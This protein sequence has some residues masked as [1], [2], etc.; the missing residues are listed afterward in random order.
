MLQVDKPT[1][2]DKFSKVEKSEKVDFDKAEIVERAGEKEGSLSE[3][4]A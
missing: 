4:I 3:M 1:K 2:G